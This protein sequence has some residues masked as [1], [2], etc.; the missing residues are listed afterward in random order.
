MNNFLLRAAGLAICIAAA[1]PFAKTPALAQANTARIIVPFGPGGGQDVM[2]RILAPELGKLLGKTFIIENR[3][4]AGSAIG[5]QFVAR[6]APDGD[7]LLMAASS[8]TISAAIRPQPLVY[9]VKEFTAVGHVGTGAMMVLVNARLPVKTVRELITHAKANPD[10]LNYASAGV[11]SATHMSMAY[12]ASRGGFNAVHVPFKST[13]EALNAV[14]TGVTQLLVVPTLGS[15]NYVNHPDVRILAVMSKNRQPSLP[16]TPTVDESG[17]PGLEFT[18]W[19]GLLGPAGIPKD[20]VEK[21]NAAVIKVV[22]MRDVTAA[23][24]KQGV[25]PKTM[26]SSDFSTLLAAHYEQ[27]KRITRDAGMVK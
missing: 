22:Q 15:Q 12:L 21:I 5:A 17:I 14:A 18:S 19:F 6:S 11:G 13:G 26:A 16:Q 3:A 10:K 1:L 7:T 25:E 27:M 8:H 9:P 23:I 24:E 2:A 4:G 20:T